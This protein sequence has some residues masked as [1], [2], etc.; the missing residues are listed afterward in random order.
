MKKIMPIILIIMLLGT[1]ALGAEAIKS[2]TTP[3]SKPAIMNDIW[4]NANRMNGIL[5]NNGTWFYDNVLGD[6]GLEWPQGSGLSPM[7][8]AGQWVGAMVEGSPRVAGIIHGHSEFQPGEI[9]QWGI[10]PPV[11]ANPTS[12]AYRWY[13]IRSD[14][15]GDWTNWPVSQG[16]PVDADGNPK[17]IG[18]QTIFCVYNDMADHTQFGTSKMGVEVRQIVWSFSRADAIGDMVFLKWQIVNKSAYDWS[19]TYLSIWT[20][21]DLGDG[22]DDFVG[23]DS[24]LGLGYLYNASD[25]D[26]QYGAAPPAIGID[27]FQGPIVDSP[28]DVVV[29][30]DGTTF[31]DK[32]MLKMTSF[33]YYNNDDSPQGNPQTG[34]DA[35]NYQRG[36][37][38]DGS[39]ITDPSGNPTRFMYTGNPEAATGWLDANES[40]RRFMMT[41]GPFVMPKWVDA[42]AD[43]IPELGEPGVQEIVAGCIVARGSSNVNSVTTLKEV[44]VLAQQAYDLNFILAKA[45]K[46]PVVSVSQAPNEIIL[47]WDETS[48]YND[49]GSPYESADPIVGAAYGDTVIID[50]IV[51][52]ISDSTYNFRGYTVYQY[53]DASGRE[54]VVVDHWDIGTPAD[55]ED[56]TNQRY[57]VLSQNKHPTVGNV[58]EALFNGKE[59]YFGV[60][61]EGYCE[62][63]APKIFESSPRIVRVIPQNTPGLRTSS[64]R[65]DSL[66]VT[67]SVTAG[68]PSDGS[69]VAIVVDPSSLTGDAYHVTFNADRTWNLLSSS[70]SSFSAAQ[71]ETLLVDQPNQRG[72]DAYNVVD[73]ILVKVV[74]PALD[75]KNIQVVANGNGPLSQPEMGCFAYN[76]NGFPFLGDWDGVPVAGDIDRP[77]EDQQVSPAEWGIHTGMN[78]VGM[79]DS[80]DYFVTR[81]TQGGARW[82]SIIPYDWEIRFTTAGGKAYIPN[83]FMTGASTG[84]VYLDV[85]FELWCIGMDKNS[86]ADDY[87]LFPYLLDVDHSATF[88]LLTQAGCDTGEGYPADHSVSGGDNDPY[89]DWIY[90]VKPANTTPGQAGYDA[91]VASIGANP[92]AHAYLDAN[93]MRGDVFRRMVFVNWNGGSVATG[94]YNATMPETG[95]IFRILTTKPSQPSDIFAFRAPSNTQTLTDKK[96]DLKRINVVPN[97][98]YGYHSGELNPFNRYVQFTYLPPECTIRIFDL[99]G[100]LIRHLRK[101]DPTTTLLQWGLDNEYELPVASGIYIYHVDVPGVGE[102]VGKIAVFTPNERLDAY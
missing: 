27:F 36:I 22:W 15:T 8:A 19:E 21:P 39:F 93:I 97:P 95:T 13:E 47:T 53:A 17:L 52:V 87:R 98:Y 31:Q 80:Y 40:D 75:Y 20:D 73:G 85:P 16:A 14:G 70:D 51:K 48:E 65:G 34:N 32:K 69:V 57:I 7:F 58:G 94:N 59:Y 6:W 33:I 90:W 49:D 46:T 66:T 68:L 26:Q 45:P 91:I 86:T 102:K 54:P 9:T 35:W 10:D 92:S 2:K 82:S 43:G 88:N 72:D 89:T 100:N 11:A 84:G 67:H 83:A 77:T 41:T 78:A 50:N 63:G 62:F 28:G 1:L 101:T 4:I 42:D 71:T 44:D 79:D 3:V 61:A 30:P 12:T 24:T 37:W 64:V 60:T 76:S 55:A 5:R 18:D 25:N 81:T 23:C 38:R 99:A 56:Y 74:G 29:L 96:A